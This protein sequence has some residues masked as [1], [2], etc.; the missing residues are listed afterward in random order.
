MGGLVDDMLRLARLDQ[1]PGEQG[2]PVSLSTLAAECV[3]RAR[4]ASPQ[5]IWRGDIADGLE[6]TGDEELL[7]RAIDNVLANVAAHTPEGSTAI[8]T[9]TRDGTRVTVEVRDDGPGC[10]PDQLPRIFDRFYRAG[11]PSRRPGSGLG[12]AIA[13]AVVAAH[14]GHVAAMAGEPHG[15]RI[16]LTLPMSS[17]HASLAREDADGQVDTAA[18][19]ETTSSART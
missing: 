18:V 2:E 3:H 5:W 14:D 8:L 1:H 7:R 17:P 9:A 19:E 13:A 16:I 4:T 6:V 12:L 11:V 10:P 15:L